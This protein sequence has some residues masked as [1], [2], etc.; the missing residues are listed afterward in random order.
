M[1]V[2][3]IEDEPQATQFIKKGLEE[4]GF[5]VETAN[6]GQTGYDVASASQFD[7]IVLDLMLPKID[8][9]EVCRRLRSQGVASRILML[10]ARDSID[11]RV[12][13]LESGADDY[14]SKPFAFRELLA[15]L[16]ALSRRTDDRDS[17][18]LEVSGMSLNLLT[19]RVSIRDKEIDLSAKEFALLE[20]FMRHP[21]Q[22]LSRTV[23][24]EHVWGYDFEHQSNVVEVYVRYLRQKLDPYFQSSCIE[25]VRGVGYRLLKQS[26]S[27]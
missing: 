18:E 2:L 6:D 22:V 3:L 11:D 10:T 19:R 27:S 12:T 1:R 20:V 14:L 21:D 24:V 13:G 25:T 7:L 4:N 23:L 8:G 17:T 16:R 9:I 26:A 15:R 5:Q